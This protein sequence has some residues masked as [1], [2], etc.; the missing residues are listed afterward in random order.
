MRF[1]RHEVKALEVHNHED[2]PSIQY[3][4]CYFND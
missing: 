2:A 4:R 1:R 3:K